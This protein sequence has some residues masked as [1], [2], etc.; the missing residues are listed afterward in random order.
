M[1]TAALVAECGARPRPL[2][3]AKEVGKGVL[4]ERLAKVIPLALDVEGAEEFRLL[5]ILFFSLLP[6]LESCRDCFRVSALDQKILEGASKTGERWIMSAWGQRKG[7]C[8]E[9]SGVKT[10]SS[11]RV[12]DLPSFWI[13]RL[14]GR[15]PKP[16]CP[17][18]QVTL[19]HT[20]IWE[21]RY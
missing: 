8:R 1:V 6:V 15:N 11:T 13:R 5:F 4:Q 19:K 9:I 2:P 17:V 18:S 20:D 7:C 16:A 12:P 3:S 21:L 10:P 14:G